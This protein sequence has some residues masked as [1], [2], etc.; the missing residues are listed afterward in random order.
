MTPL[1][2]AIGSGESE[3]LEWKSAIKINA[4]A[5]TICAF[6]NGNGGRIVVGVNEEGRP[7]D[8][9]VGPGE[10]SS[11]ESQLREAISPSGSW[12]CSLQTVDGHQ[13]LLI[14]VSGGSQKPYL[15]EG[16]IWVRRGATTVHATHRD[17]DKLI[18]RRAHLEERWERRLAIGVKPEDLDEHELRAAIDDIEKRGHYRFQNKANLEAAL[19][20]LSLTCDGRLT[21]ASVMLFGRNPAARFPQVGIRVIGYPTDK[22]GQVFA[23]DEQIRGHL[24]DALHRIEGV[25]KERIAV[26]S[27]FV[28]GELRRRDQSEY[29]FGALREGIMNAL[30]HRDL[31]NVAGG[32]TI[33]FFTGRIEIWNAGELPDGLTPAGLRRDHPSLPRNP[34]IAHVCFLR[35]LIERIGRGTQLIARECAAAGMKPPQWKSD[36]VGTKLTFFG[37][38]GRPTAALSLNRRQK[39]VVKKVKTGEE[40]TV[41]EFLQI[42]APQQVTD[43]TARADLASLVRDGYFR[44]VGKGRSTSYQRTDVPL[45]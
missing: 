25:L 4:I 23:F 26:S 21:N 12:S 37:R 8:L 15:V 2:E 16:T 1:K 9:D 36:H 43:R 39:A 44:Q 31:D 22:T 24:F 11:A 41:V 18:V 30:V 33:S 6:L 34:D 17:I 20:E 7:V 5:Q 14:D 10:L 3:A 29:P 45:P 35:G 32:M 19:A 28:Q 27:E 40:I 42:L 13:L 38:R